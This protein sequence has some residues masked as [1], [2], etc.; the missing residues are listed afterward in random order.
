[1]SLAEALDFPLISCD[2]YFAS[3]F[4]KQKLKE[5]ESHDEMQA[6]MLAEMQTISLKLSALLKRP[7]VVFQK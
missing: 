1:M 3:D 7:P 2:L 6:Q 4:W 5:I